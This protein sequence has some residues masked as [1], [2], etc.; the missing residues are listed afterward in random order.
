[1]E[2]TVNQDPPV[3]NISTSDVACA[4]ETNGSISVESVSSGTPPYSFSLNGGSSTTDR[5]FNNLPAGDYELRVVDQNGCEDVVNTTISSPSPL[6]V[7]IS[8]SATATPVPLGDS[9]QLRAVLN[10][11][12]N[13]IQSIV[14]EPGNLPVC[15]TPNIQNCLSFFTTPS[16][17]TLYRVSVT[18]ING[19]IVTAELLVQVEKIRPV[20]I[21][22]AF[23]PT[24][25]DGI[26]DL[27]LIYGGP[28][29]SK[30]KSFLIFD[31]WGNLIHEYYNFDP[32][33]QRH[34][35]DGT[36][37]GKEMN[38]NVYVFFAEI[39]FLD[40]EVE[41]YKGDVTLK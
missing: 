23:S 22:S 24:D 19:C 14:W 37:K 27:F 5:D 9:I 32:S 17:T 35:W 36:Y 29:I 11:G 41:I 16:G 21:P 6:T 10:V 40:G 30:V 26:N 34:G 39:E 31:R 28:Q 33:D 13:Q 2:I 15:D 8:L 3:L 20:Y 12:P 1:M 4:G 25:D 7:S 38:S 18:D